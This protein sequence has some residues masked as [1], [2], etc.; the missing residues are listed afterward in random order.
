MPALK[1]AMRMKTRKDW[2][3]YISIVD[4]RGLMREILEL[5]IS[6]FTIQFPTGYTQLMSSGG[7]VDTGGLGRSSMQRLFFVGVALVGTARAAALKAAMKMKTRKDWKA[8]ISIVDTRGSMREALELVIGSLSFCFCG[9][10][11]CL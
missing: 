7:L 1:A 5:V 11:A 3:A 10:L 9:E 6:S 2:K 4:S 8:S